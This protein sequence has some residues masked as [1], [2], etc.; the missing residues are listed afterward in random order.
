[1][2]P[3]YYDE[4]VVGGYSKGLTPLIIRITTIAVVV[5]S[6]FQSSNSS[7]VTIATLVLAAVLFEVAE[8]IT[9]FLDKSYKH[10]SSEGFVTANIYR[11]ET[12]EYQWIKAYL[13]Q[14]QIFQDPIQH[15][16][17]VRGLPPR[18]RSQSFWWH[19]SWVEV[20]HCAPDID[21]Y[22]PFGES[23]LP[24]KSEIHVTV[25][26]LRASPIVK[27]LQE[28]KSVFLSVDRQEKISVYFLGQESTSTYPS[29]RTPSWSERVH[30]HV[31][32]M[33]STSLSVDSLTALVEESA[34][35]W[36]SE[37]WYHEVGLPFRK[38]YLL[39]GP[40]G[41]GKRD[42]V[43]AVA[44]KLGRV[45]YSLCASS[46]S[47][48]LLLKV[49]STIPKGSIL[50][51]E[52]IERGFKN[53]SSTSPNLLDDSHLEYQGPYNTQM[54]G[55]CA[56][57]SGIIEM[58]D[59]VAKE[60]GVLFFATTSTLDGI[61]SALFQPGRIDKMIDF[62][63]ISKNRANDIFKRFFP[64][65]ATSPNPTGFHQGYLD[66][67]KHPVP[68]DPAEQ[69][70]DQIP[71]NEF[72]ISD[73]RFYLMS[74]QPSP[75][76]A[77]SGVAHWIAAKREEKAK[78]LEAEKKAKH[79]AQKLAREQARQATIIIPP[80]D[81]QWTPLPFPSQPLIVSSP[82]SDTAEATDCVPTSYESPP[83]DEPE[84]QC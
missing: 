30:K 66:D 34:K 21:E 75:E 13:T 82:M 42:A 11:E 63:Y 49:V 64:S 70:S 57:P 67:V 73:I 15:L 4:D 58:L 29:N 16:N 12:M 32:L 25:Y 22:V 77:V 7:I 72:T 60:D 56:T 18:R 43:Y 65:S 19:G 74:H 61:D 76:A 38:G 84:E 50:L 28:A 44:G 1:M 48:S 53:P 41:S 8:K 2:P 71:D 78:N 52:N 36:E 68:L 33:D 40:S 14:K 35:F 17:K 62:G 24:S 39:H 46:I 20:T 9:H 80:I 83:N 55:T 37:A 6:F 51:L 59:A 26:S 81:G 45:V 47:D 54:N 31:R 69:F 23:R 3:F 10:I 5:G 27:F 79:D